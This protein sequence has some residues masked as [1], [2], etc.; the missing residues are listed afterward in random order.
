MILG[1]KYE[2]PE[3]DMWSLGFQIPN[4]GVILF[5][6]L[7]GHLPFDD[8]NMKELYKKIANGTYKT[9]DHVPTS[10]LQFNIDARHLIN[11]LITV[12]PKKRATLKEVLQHP[13]VNEGHDTIPQSY[14][15]K[16]L[17]INDPSTLSK[18]ITN[19]LEIFGYS[20][21]DIMEAFSP[22]QDHS[23]PSAIRSTYHLLSE[24]V[25]REQHRL[26]THRKQQQKLAESR[27]TFTSA[28]TLHEACQSQCSITEEG[29]ESRR[30]GMRTVS[31]YQGPS[32]VR[33]RSAV[34]RQSLP[35][36]IP[37]AKP[38]S[39]ADKLREEFRV[40]SG[41]FLNYSTTSTKS[42]SDILGQLFGVLGSHMVR[43][44]A[45]RC[46]FQ[47]EIDYN[48]VLFERTSGIPVKPQLVEILVEISK[49]PK[50]ELNAIHFK[51]LTGGVWNY[52]KVANKILSKL[53]L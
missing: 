37:N 15:P 13:W 31:H 51:R 1:K 20:K 40:V 49:V 24:M 34:R 29:E 33:E 23:K 52:K 26:R 32:G 3:V 35:L 17:Y 27:S 18:D 2:G 9:P 38:H 48:H 6:L 42:Q 44:E 14:I 47:C 45:D 28:N 21:H 5:A 12:D 10:K 39:T 46:S 41:W 7:C 53:V 36:M 16:R 8:D 4:P 25:L 22:N 50:M 43:Y 30:V 19:R 11:R